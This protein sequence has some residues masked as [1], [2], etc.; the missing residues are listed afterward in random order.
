MCQDR[1]ISFLVNFSVTGVAFI[2]RGGSL[3]FTVEVRTVMLKDLIF[4]S[5]IDHLFL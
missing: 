3:W 2:V 5:M 4:A 1:T